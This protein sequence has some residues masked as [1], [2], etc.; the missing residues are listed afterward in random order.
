MY[1]MRY[2][3]RLALLM[4]FAGPAWAQGEGGTSYTEPFLFVPQAH[5]FAALSGT[6][7][8]ATFDVPVANVG[9]GN[10]AA[11]GAFDRAALGLAYQLDTSIKGGYFSEAFD[12]EADNDA[13]P[14]SAAVVAPVGA[15]RIGASYVQRHA[16]GLGFDTILG[17]PG[18]S[19]ADTAASSITACVETFSPQAAVRVESALAEEDVLVFGLRLGFG[20]AG[21]EERLDTLATRFSDWGTHFA[22]GASYRTGTAKPL[23]LGL[24]YESGLR[25]EAAATRRFPVSGGPGGGEVEI[26]SFPVRY[27]D[28]LPGRLGLSLRYEPTPTLRVGADAARV[29]WEETSEQRLDQFD[30]SAYAQLDVA[31]DALVSFGVFSQGRGYFENGDVF[32]YSGRAVYLALGGAVTFEHV[33]LDAALADS[34]LLAASEH[35]QTILKVGASVQL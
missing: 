19:S 26:A 29:F 27:D 18:T 28:A 1:P 22:V 11:L 10:P 21:F 16:G 7:L 9:A 13:R 17:L 5:R 4:L 34:H 33:R 30:A 15:F 32:D 31:E 8:S 25:F 35:R 3:T 20:R 23:G 14:Q 2:I 12:Y 6:S 24:Y